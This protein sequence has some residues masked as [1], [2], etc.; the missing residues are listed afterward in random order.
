M[1]IPPV[2]PIAVRR[3]GMDSTQ[4]DLDPPLPIGDWEV[5]SEVQAD[6]DGIRWRVTGH[7]KSTGADRNMLGGFLRLAE[8]DTEAVAR[9]AQRWGVLG[10]CEKHGLPETHPLDLDWYLHRP[11]QGGGAG[12]CPYAKAT[13]RSWW[14]EAADAWQELARQGAA[15][16]TLAVGLH[17]GDTGDPAVWEL[18]PDYPVEIVRSH[19]EP[20]YVTFRRI[21]TPTPTAPP[22][23]LEEGRRVLAMHVDLWLH[24]GQVRNRLRWDGPDPTLELQPHGLFGA[25]AMQL[26]SR[27][28]GRAA[29]AI[30]SNCQM[31]YEP[32]RKPNP[33]QRRYCPA[34]REARVPQ[35]DAKRDLR[36]RKAAERAEKEESV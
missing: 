12:P 30:C 23:D 17:E 22:Q 28:T 33:N 8:A 18:L 19:S 21:W 7:R 26:A 5:P 1:S 3:H 35:R 10:L 13:E 24:L 15:I 4:Y 36:A 9:Y 34:C 16:L 2:D 31:P 20:A 27:V 11:L 29:V 32:E 6:G 14:Y 25:L